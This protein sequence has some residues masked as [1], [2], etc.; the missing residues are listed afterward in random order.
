MATVTISG[1]S[2]EL[3]SDGTYDY[4]S[5]QGTTYYYR[6]ANTTQWFQYTVQA[7]SSGT[8]TQASSRSG[9]TVPAR[10]YNRLA[11]NVYDGSIGTIRVRWGP[12]AQQRLLTEAPNKGI[13]VDTMKALTEHF[14]YLMAARVGAVTAVIKYVRQETYLHKTS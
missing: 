10:Y 3:T 13:S 7:Q 14:T 8:T 9:G 1:Y 2:Y 5:N 11:A 4:A 6:R 12:A